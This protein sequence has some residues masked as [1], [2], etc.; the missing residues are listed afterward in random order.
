MKSYEM[1]MCTG[2][3]WKKIMVFSV[4][5]MF[6]NI[7]QIVFNI[8]DVAVV[9][10]F[11]G[12][13]ALGAVGSTSILITLSTGILLGLSSGVSALT[14]LY[15]G[16]KDQN[17][18]KKTVHTSALLLAFSGVAIMVLGI[19]FAGGI[20]SAM[21]TKDELIGGA[22]RYF[23][24]YLLGTPALAMF[25]FGNAVLSAAGDT[26]RP[27]YYLTFAGVVNVLLNLFFVIVG[28]MGV[29]GVAIASIISQYIS[30]VLVLRLL[31]H[32]NEVFALRV[33]DLHMDREK[34]RRILRIGVPSAL[35]YAL[36]AIANLFVQTS[37]NYF[38]HVMVEGNSAAANADPLVYDMMAAFYTACTSFIAQNMGAKQ[39]E[40][41]LKSYF[42]CLLYS[43][44]LGL[45]LGVGIYGMRFLFLSLFTSERAVV[46][47]GIRRLSV[48]AL[49][50]S[51]S[52]FMDCSI[53]AS[54]GLGRTIVP[55]LLVTAGSTVFR[56]IWIGTVFAH[57]RTIESLYLLYVFSWIITGIAEMVYFAKIV[58][59]VRFAG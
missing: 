33:E 51:V 41:I 9:G 53:A 32:S 23:R 49:S 54:R 22:V 5:L 8:S 27:L 43:F 19:L 45:F 39:R 14:A 28:K 56:L 30:A 12:P 47:A 40:R 55:M 16:A 31:L 3:L 1:D 36:F 44:A 17:S 50:Y 52:A 48:M 10:K 18:V 20:L 29:S 46:D 42:I 35:Q 24:I 57:Y 2:S 21:R 59:G 7:L 58:R 4:P 15:I 25:N 13:I 11:A 34:L 26:K 37:V 6:S 38:D